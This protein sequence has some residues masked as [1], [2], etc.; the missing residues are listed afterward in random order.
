MEDRIIIALSRQF[1]SGGHNI[2]KRLAKVLDIDFYDEELIVAAAQKSGIT[3]G[4]VKAVEESP[5]GSLLY[6]I[7]A[8]SPFA[9]GTTNVVM[10]EMPMADKVF[11]AQSEVIHQYANKGSCVIVGRCAEHVLQKDSDLLSVFI[12]RDREERVQQVRKI[13]DLSERKARELV[14]KTD[15]RRTSYISYYTDTRWGAAENYD[16][17]LDS[18]TLGEDGCV[19]VLVSAVENAIKRRK[20]RR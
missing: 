7:A 15:K 12:G 9:T 17:C 10:P 3:E 11:I 13:Y 6:A 19:A 14:K 5:A 8:G 1:G 4:M 20:T 18:G 2:G 16:I